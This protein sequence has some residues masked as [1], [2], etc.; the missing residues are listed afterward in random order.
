MQI[1]IK[2][3]AA[4]ALVLSFAGM[5]KADMAP[6]TEL[7]TFSFQKDGQP[8]AQ[9]VNFTVTCY[10]TTRFDPAKVLKISDFSE[11]CQTYGCKFDT[12]SVFEV[13]NQNTNH[14]DLEGDAGGQK[15]SVKSFLVA[16]T[17]G[18][19]GLS[20]NWDNTS[21]IKFS[22]DDKYYKETSQYRDCVSAVNKE[23]PPGDNGPFCYKFLVSTPKSEC[24]KAGY[25]TLGGVCYRATNESYQCQIE[26]SQKEK[27]CR[28]YLEDVSSKIVKTKDGY[29]FQKICET[30]IIIPAGISKQPTT[31]GQQIPMGAFSRFI[32]F[33]KCPF[34]KFLGKSC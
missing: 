24:G 29:P 5:S 31:P 26:M 6:P 7:T 23:Y 9:P 8:F 19:N 33:F 3:L 32:N 20:C 25:L 1:K 18:M 28:Q 30:K 4:T 34:L 14:C 16:D 17:N 15:F 22:D 13:Y 11:T 2:I 12:S 10:G 21:D 27:L